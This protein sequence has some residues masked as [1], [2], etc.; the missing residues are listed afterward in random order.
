ML[1]FAIGFSFPVL[2]P[3]RQTGS[4]VETDLFL[5]FI[6]IPARFHT[7]FDFKL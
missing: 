1:D 4:N 2:S 6:R 7:R 5:E 3:Y